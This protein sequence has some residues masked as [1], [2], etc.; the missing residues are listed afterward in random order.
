MI[1]FGPMV[2][3]FLATQPIDFRKGVHGLVAVVAEGLGGEPTAATFMSSDRS[4]RIV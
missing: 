2:R 3:V 1:S 4:D